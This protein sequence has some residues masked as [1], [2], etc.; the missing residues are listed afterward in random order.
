MKKVLVFNGSIRKTGNTAHLV[1]HFVTGCREKTDR[2]EIVDADALNLDYCAGCLRCNIIKRCSI[3]GD[4]WPELSQKILDADVL[5]FASPIYF[6]HVSSQLKKI[7]DRFR[8]FV[9]VQITEDVLVHTPHQ[10]WKKDFVLLLSMG[11][12]DNKD[13][14]PVKDLFKYMCGILGP[15]NRLHVI[16]GTRLAVTNHVIKSQEDLEALYPKMKLPVELAKGDY[17]SNQLTLNNCRI[18]GSK[19]CQRG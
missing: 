16:E 6:H 12:P 1:T 7:I 5:V 2:I 14:E 17:L 8:S 13:A 11:S 9:H 19:L 15:E 10:D 3:R 18:L 4:E